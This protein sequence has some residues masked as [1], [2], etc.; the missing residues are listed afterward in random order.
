LATKGKSAEVN[1]LVGFAH[2]VS[3][4]LFEIAVRDIKPGHWGAMSAVEAMP[5]ASWLV[6]NFAAVNRTDLADDLITVLLRRANW[7]DFPPQASGFTQVV[8]L[9]AN[10]PA[11]ANGLIEPFCKAVCTETWLRNAYVV[12]SCGQLASGLRQLALYH[13][14]E[15]CRQFHHRGLGGRIYKE[16]MRFQSATQHDQSQII[17]LLGS[18]GLCGWA[19]G[20]QS[21][22]SIPLEAITILPHRPDVTKIETRQLQFW[23]GLRTFVSIRR[24]RLPVPRETIEETL[25][26]W[27]TNLEETSETPTSAAH[28]VNESMVKWLENC[29]LAIPPALVPTPEP[30]WRLAGFPLSLDLPNRY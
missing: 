15:R 12:T 29:G 1:E 17:Q 28:R 10:V 19:V 18:A 14:V 7:Q 22:R 9:L 6:L 26:L 16:L 27:R 8:R 24:A 25:K 23:L 30:L 5:G 13:T 20:Q 4:K 11:T 2:Y 21:L 3:S